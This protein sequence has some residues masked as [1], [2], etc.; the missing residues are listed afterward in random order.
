MRVYIVA[1]ALLVPVDASAQNL[2]P[3]A[4][5]SASVDEPLVGE[6][7]TFSATG[8]FDPDE[9]PSPLAARWEFD[10]GQSADGLEVSHAFLA[11]GAYRV[12]VTVDDGEARA[13]AGLTVFVLAPPTT[14]SASAGAIAWHDDRV[15]VAD[16][17]GGAVWALEPE[18]GEL[19]RRDVC[20][21]P[22]HVAAHT[23][24]EGSR[25]LVACEGGLLSLD[26]E[27]VFSA[28]GGVRSVA[29]SGVHTL[30]AT[31]SGALV[32]LDATL[33]ERA[34][35]SVGD[36]DAI[37]IAG[38]RAWA[39]VFLTRTPET[40]ARIV[41]ID[42]A[43]GEVVAT[44]RLDRDRSDDTP[45]SGGG[46]VNL[47]SAL[48]VTPSGDTLWV[49]ATKS[50][51]GRGEWLDGRPLTPENRTRGLLAPLTLPGGRDAAE[52][53]IDT[54][55][56]GRVSALALTERG[57]FAFALH[58]GIGA[59]SVYD[60]A[61]ATLYR[62]G[63]PG[64]T[65]P[66]E[67]RLELGDT[68]DAILLR[69]E[70]LFVRL[71]EALAIV[72]VDVSTPSRP[73]VAGRFGYGPDPRP[74]DVAWGARLFA[75]SR[76]PVHSRGGYI[77]CTGCHPGG[78]HDGRTW[79]FT[80]SGEGLRNTIDL[81]G[82]GGL[83][84][85]PLH[86]TANFDEVQDFENDI[87][88]G[89]GGAGLAADGLPP[90]PPDG[91]PNAG[92]SEALDALAAYVSSLD[93]APVSPFESD[94]AVARGRAVFFDPE[95]GCARCHAGARFTDSSFEAPIRHDV[96]T[97]RPSS[98]A[99]LGSPLDGLDTPSLIGVWA[100]AP[101]L[102]DGRAE[103]L[104]AVLTTHN[105][106]DRHG[107]TSH[108]EPAALADLVAFLRSLDEPAAGVGGTCGVSRTARGSSVLA[109]LLLCA[110]LALR[111]CRAR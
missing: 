38:D 3:V 26:G 92:R 10:D 64:A 8:S 16:P 91:P 23:S 68:P 106:R 13:E 66:F 110:L 62:G 18:S 42:L 95:V 50:N 79:D 4:R 30:A 48:A 99:R 51:T 15:F 7:V 96:G 84:D 20:E 59:L 24:P 107:A 89:F 36:V 88:H 41:E 56:A 101:Y 67:A 108:L 57:R 90:H 109:P 97:L 63:D 46:V 37:A 82:R 25:V 45:S 1:L 86:W 105:E 104:L 2:P 5:L 43:L 77:A 27:V 40:A 80:Q 31:A 29:S 9:S 35:L 17:I 55:D 73:A 83:L 32:L 100:S 58:P 53:R 81:R 34:R 85:G 61:A 72:V 54:N 39:A 74:A 6:V 52:L 71:R 103:S 75:S 12:R 98:G 47:L 21:R 65:V 44:H 111:P 94:D 93:V 11:A 76:P 60:L 102:H 19:S 22:T 69:G 70:R 33:S 28:R 14:R 78:G 49:G 87:V